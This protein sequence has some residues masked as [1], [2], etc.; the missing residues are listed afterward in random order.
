MEINSPRMDPD[1]LQ[2]LCGRPTTTRMQRNWMASA[3]RSRQK[4]AIWIE[5]WELDCESKWADACWVRA[6]PSD[7]YSELITLDR[8]STGFV[9][10]QT[11]P[12]WWRIVV[13]VG[14]AVDV[15]LCIAVEIWFSCGR[16]RWNFTMRAECFAVI[17][18]TFITDSKSHDV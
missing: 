15:L 6:W 5:E 14:C 13:R 17:F 9:E 16:R 10:L 4:E 2:S 3:R 11:P 7:L 18:T 1:P 12:H 8:R